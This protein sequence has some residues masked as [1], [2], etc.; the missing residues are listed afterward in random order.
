M[1]GREIP[2]VIKTTVKTEREENEVKNCLLCVNIFC[3]L[4]ECLLKKCV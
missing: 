4:F 2:V 3:I 1:M